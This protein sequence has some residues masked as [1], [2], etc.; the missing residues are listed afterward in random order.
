[1]VE[2]ANALAGASASGFP[3]RLTATQFEIPRNPLFASLSRQ[4][5]RLVL[6]HIKKK[7]F[8]QGRAILLEGVRN[9]GKIYIIL[10]GEVALAKE[11]ISPV[12][13][14]PTTYEIGALRR[15]DIFGEVSFVDGK[16]SAVTFLAKSDITVAVLDLGA[17]HLKI[18]TRR[19]RDIV[20]GKLRRHLAM[21]AH[22]SAMLRVNG[23]QLENQFAAYRSGVGHIIVTT[24]CVLSF[25][26]LA[27][28]FLPRFKSIAHANFALSPLIIMF[29][30]LS[31]FPT[32][33]TS[34]F[35][36]RFF[37]LRL[38]NW[39][40]ALLLSLEASA[41]FLALLLIVKWILIRS[42]TEFSDLPLIGNAQIEV[43]D[44]TMTLG[45]WYWFALCLYIFL[46]PMQ[47]FVARSGI[48]A[49]LYAFLHGSEAKRQWCAIVVSN[50]VFAAAHAHISVVFAFASFLPGLL[51][52]WIFAR[53]NSLLAAT[54][55]HLLVGGLA[56][57]VLGVESIVSKFST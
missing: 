4:Q 25:Y 18:R 9:P 51:W 1:M 41:I 46:T 49:P 10:E 42:V 7:K 32:V 55:S 36:A 29:C 40:R 48:Q 15:G 39:R 57:F 27:L 30:A 31:F 5:L 21:Q 37:G 54:F 17:S 11:G 16:P 12:E 20:V 6:P 45:S 43:D 56:I 14:R 24:L 26:T 53:T 52:G 13:A 44:Q 35:P 3:S 22:E 2:L 47:E 19:V 38:D 50:L 23:L 8:R 33:A 34:G 28:S